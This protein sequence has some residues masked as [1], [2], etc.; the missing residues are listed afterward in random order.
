MPILNDVHSLAI[1]SANANFSA[2]VYTEIYVGANTSAVVNGQLITFSAGS[3][4]KLKVFSISG[5]TGLTLMGEKADNQA[6]SPNA[7]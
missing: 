2:H 7:T 1:P 5:G 3:N 4:L 6:G